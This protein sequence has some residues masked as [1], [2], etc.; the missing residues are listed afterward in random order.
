MIIHR[1]FVSFLVLFVIRWLVGNIIGWLIWL[2]YK[3]KT[4]QALDILHW[5]K[6]LVSWNFKSDFI[7]GDD[8][9]EIILDMKKVLCLPFVLVYHRLMLHGKILFILFVSVNCIDIM[10]LRNGAGHPT[11]TGAI[12]LW[13]GTKDSYLLNAYGHYPSDKI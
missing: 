10:F 13:L 5:S 6:S 3:T 4:K 8:T 7:D 1:N 12:N 2:R 11:I 9:M